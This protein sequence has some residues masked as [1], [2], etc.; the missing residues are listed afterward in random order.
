MR[1][2]SPTQLKATAKRRLK[3]PFKGSVASCIEPQPQAESPKDPDSCD[4]WEEEEQAWKRRVKVELPEDRAVGQKSKFSFTKH[5]EK[6][7]AYNNNF[8]FGLL[9]LDKIPN[10][11]NHFKFGLILWMAEYLWRQKKEWAVESSASSP[12]PQ[13]SDV[14][15]VDPYL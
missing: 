13:G 14:A 9:H 4:D 10:L 6:R 8:K 2:K 12:E 7:L 5:S 3:I 1:P 11:D 15:A